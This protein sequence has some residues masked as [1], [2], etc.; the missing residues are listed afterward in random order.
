MG[1][2]ICLHGCYMLLQR[3]IAK[4]TPVVTNIIVGK[5]NIP[6]ENLRNFG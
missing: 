1:P 5:T 4:I 6:T 2:K 3:S